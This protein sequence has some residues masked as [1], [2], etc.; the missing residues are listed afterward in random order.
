MYFNNVLSPQIQLMLDY[1]YGQLPLSFF[2]TTGMKDGDIWDVL[3]HYRGNLNLPSDV[4]KVTILNDNYATLSVHRNLIKKISMIPEINYISLP[5]VMNYIMYEEKAEVCGGRLDTKESGYDVS[6]E[7]VYFGLIDSGIDYTHPDFINED[8][9][10]R[11]LYLWDQTIEGKP[12]KGFNHGTEYSNEEIN[13]ALKSAKP[14]DLVPS[15]DEINH[16]TALCS[17]AAGNGRG[18]KKY[19][20]IAPK[21][22]LIIVKAGQEGSAEIKGKF[23]GPRNTEIMMGLKYLVEKSQTAN[24]PISILLGVGFE[25]GAHN[26]ASPLAEYID[27]ITENWKV[28]VTVGAGNQA[29]QECH[30]AGVVKSNESEKISVF[31]DNGQPYY[32]ATICKNFIDSFGVRVITPNGEKTSLLTREE[33]N[34]NTIVGDLIISINFSQATPISQGEQIII[35]I[36]SISGSEIS[37]GNWTIELVGF[38]VLDGIYDAWSNMLEP[39]NRKMRF[40]APV[41]KMTITIP[42]TSISATSVGATSSNGLDIATFSGQGYMGGD[43]VKPDICAPGIE[44]DVASSGGGYRKV[45]G[46]SAS[47]AFV[48][49]AYLLLLEY[50]MRQ[51]SDDDYLYGEMLKAY[52]LRT[53]KRPFGTTFPNIEWGYG[54]LCIKSALQLLSTLYDSL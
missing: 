38:F 49:G 12:P 16:G 1:P 46:T 41:K 14:F 2:S 40:D 47:A 33:I 51:M 18:D 23:R 53:A 35:F 25:L 11:I 15:K 4:H 31:I 21:A 9:S 30:T 24:K 29:S 42:A 43:S 48:A 26:G 54:E 7:G 28:N 3:V 32:I 17:I 5:E 37:D 36:D 22:S 13:N 8:G 10:S 52:L 45:T 19:K 6:G 39:Y 20:G 50:G 27:Y 34:S 44:V